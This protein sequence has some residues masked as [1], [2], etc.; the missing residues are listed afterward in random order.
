LY[1]CYTVAVFLALHTAHNGNNLKHACAKT[2]EL[3]FSL[4]SSLAINYKILLYGGNWTTRMG[5]GR[6][7]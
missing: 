2:L 7:I 5:L 1:T 3:P 4:L 6:P